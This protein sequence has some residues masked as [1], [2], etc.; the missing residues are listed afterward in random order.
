MPDLGM[1]DMMKQARDLQ[2]RIGKAQKKIAKAEVTASA[3]GGM[4]VVVVNGKLQVRKVTLDSS[5]VAG[6]DVAMMQDLITAAV[7]A[8]IQKAQA[9][10]AEEMKQATGGLNLPG[11]SDLL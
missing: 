5:L 9:M 3:G 7:N 10:V 8:A 2:K 6:G 11:L 1:L 4:V